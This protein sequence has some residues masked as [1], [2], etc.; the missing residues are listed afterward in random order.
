MSEDFKQGATLF[1]IDY[2]SAHMRALLQQ[3]G[4]LGLKVPTDIGAARRFWEIT[5]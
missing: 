5:C 1:R 4:G 3:E 2:T